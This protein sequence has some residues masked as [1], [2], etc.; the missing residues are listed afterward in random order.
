MNKQKLKKCEKCDGHGFKM[1]GYYGAK[2]VDCSKCDGY[3]VVTVNDQKIKS[4]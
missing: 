4:K 3:G 2:Q 1:T